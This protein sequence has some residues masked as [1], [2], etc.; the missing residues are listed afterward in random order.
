MKVITL[1][2]STLFLAGGQEELV[3][4]HCVV[5]EGA[6]EH[7]DAE[8]QSPE[9]ALE[10][11]ESYLKRKKEY[12]VVVDD[13][14]QATVTVEV[15]GR[16]FVGSGVQMSARTT[17]RTE[18][19]DRAIFM[20]IKAGTHSSEL[21]ARG[22]EAQFWKMVG[23]SAADKVEEWVKVNYETLLEIQQNKE[24]ASERKKK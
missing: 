4:V 13:P 6:S 21:I 22:W 5:A 3:R 19:T 16:G 14:T 24:Q 15:L 8:L 9:S 10:D 7:A 20:R 23:R 2:L 12:L 11:L 18:G 1:L 17:R